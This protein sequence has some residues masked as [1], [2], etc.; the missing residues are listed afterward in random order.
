MEQWLGLKSYYVWPSWRTSVDVDNFCSWW[1]ADKLFNVPLDSKEHWRVRK[2][3]WIV[4][5]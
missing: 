4:N 2:Q 5:L 3:D 1:E